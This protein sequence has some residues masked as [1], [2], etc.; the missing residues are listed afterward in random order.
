MDDS[1]HGEK[2]I[3]RVPQS[4]MTAVSPLRRGY[5]PGS[6]RANLVVCAGPSSNLVLSVSQSYIITNAV[7]AEGRRCKLA[8]RRDDDRAP[9]R[10]PPDSRQNKD[11]MAHDRNWC[12]AAAMIW[13]ARA[14][15]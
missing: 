10:Y 12:A 8:G 11:V 13:L 5:N 7:Q 3:A 6:N 1:N 4:F 15:K 9:H 14:G 2:T